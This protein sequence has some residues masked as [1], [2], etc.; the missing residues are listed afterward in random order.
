MLG[1]KGDADAGIDL[2]RVAG[3]AVRLA[4]GPQQAGCQ[5]LGVALRLDVALQDGELV[6]AEP[7]Y[8]IRA[9]DGVVQAASHALQ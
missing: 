7:R 3:Y 4:D 1:R 8:Q 5:A 9:P 6:A 2:Q